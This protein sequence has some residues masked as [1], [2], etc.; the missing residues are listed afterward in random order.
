MHM[1]ASVLMA[2][3]ILAGVLALGAWMSATADIYH[4]IDETGTTHFSDRPPPIEDEDD[5]AMHEPVDTPQADSAGIPEQVPQAP[6]H[7]SPAIGENT[8]EDA[9]VES[10]PALSAI[11][12]DEDSTQAPCV[13]DRC[14][15][16]RPALAAPLNDQG[17]IKI[18][19]TKREVIAIWGSPD[20]A[21]RRD[22]P[23]GAVNEWFYEEGPDFTQRI[24]FRGDRV[25]RVEIPP[26]PRP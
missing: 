10:S 24:F 2:C 18:G 21:R 17:D 25:V 1:P 6:A 19:M 7:D 16:T 11:A 14:L 4:W 20:Y 23:E 9:G 5:Q 13:G 22:L 8:Q 15:N 12:P 3:R 26:V